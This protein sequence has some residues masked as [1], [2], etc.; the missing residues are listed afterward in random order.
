MNTPERKKFNTLIYDE[1]SEWFIEFRSGDVDAAERRRFV[2]WLRTS[3][4]HV[5]AYVELAA[6]WNEGVKIDAQ[7]RIDENK[8]VEQ[9]LREANV[10]SLDLHSEPRSSQPGATGQQIPISSGS[11]EHMP[12][13]AGIPAPLLQSAA[14]RASTSVKRRRAGFLLA[15]SLLVT[16]TGLAVWLHAQRALYSTDFGEQRSVTLPDGSE[17]TLNAK[18][19]LRV[20][21]SVSGRH[22]ELL[23]GEAL[24][25]VAKDATRPF[26]VTS[27]NIRVRALGTQFDVYSRDTGTTV[28]VIEGRVSVT[29]PAPR[30][31]SS[32]QVAPDDVRS[33][34]VLLE[35]PGGQFLLLA[36]EQA[37]VSSDAAVKARQPNVSAATAW[38]QHSLVFES[39]TLVEVAEQ[40]NRYN[41]RRL[42]IRSSDLYDFHI[43]GTFSS[44]DPGSLLR[45]LQTRPGIVITQGD[46]E[47]QVSKRP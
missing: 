26:D 7:R 46:D 17:V 2:T 32:Q 34:P 30:T 45:F 38:T 36:G 35:P 21:F 43:T 14:T 44:T 8:L 10:A 1:A 12:A 3:P 29:P 27:N 5:R 22:I 16:A 18:T 39:A 40:F 33:R 28:S 31:S 11:P 41:R 4:E 42:V 19:R 13:D 23:Q 25:N 15:A 20:S 37:V 47:I 24:F 9:A 6:I